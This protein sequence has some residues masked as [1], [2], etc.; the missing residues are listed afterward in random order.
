M[1]LEKGVFNTNMGQKDFKVKL[2]IKNDDQINDKIILW[3]FDF[4]FEQNHLKSVN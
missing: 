3:Y 1:I 2:V 4:F